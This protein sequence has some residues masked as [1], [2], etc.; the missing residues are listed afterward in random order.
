[1]V[2]MEKKIREALHKEHLLELRKYSLGELIEA[3]NSQ[4]CVVVELVDRNNLISKGKLKDLKKNVSG[5]PGFIII[6]RENNISD[7]DRES[8]DYLEIDID[9]NKLCTR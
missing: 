2:N 7:V 8:L 9:T 6:Y 4:H 5:G 1:M 3:I